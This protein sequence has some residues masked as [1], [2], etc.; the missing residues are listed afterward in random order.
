MLSIPQAFF[1]RH[2]RRICHGGEALILQ[3]SLKAVGG[4]KG[5]AELFCWR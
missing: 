3:P 2:L 5:G 4:R 1:R